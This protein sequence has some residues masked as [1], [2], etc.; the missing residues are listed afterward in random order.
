MRSKNALKSLLALFCYEAVIFATSIVYPR[1]I[2]LTYG[3]EVNGLS[4]TITRAL[5]LVSLIQAGAIGASIYQMYQP[6]AENDVVTQSEIMYSS[7][8][9]YKKIVLIYLSLSLVIA[10]FFS[11]YLGNETLF[12]KDIFL[13]F[14]I[15]A[16]NGGL[17]LYITSICDI[18]FSAHQKKY[19]VTIAQIVYQVV[20]YGC[21]TLVLYYKLSYIY[22]FLSMLLGGLIG[23]LINLLLYK[24]F[25]KGII[26][27]NPENKNY[28]IP[29]RR[30]LMLSCIG[31]EAVTTAPT[32]IVSTILGLIYS[33][34]FSVYSLVYMSMRTLISTIQLSVSPIF[35]NLV[36]T[37]DDSKLLYIYDLIELITVLFGTLLSAVAGV[38]IIPFIEIY[39]KDINDAEYLYPV[40]AIFVVAFIVFLT[41]SSA[42]GYVS[43]IYGLFK[44]T[45]TITLISSGVGI[46]ISAI[47]TVLWG[48]SYVMVGVIIYQVLSLL[49]TLKVLQKNVRWFRLSGIIKRSVFLI[50]ATLL[51]YNLYVM[52]RVEISTWSQWFR[53]A[54]FASIATGGIISIYVVLFERKPVRDIISYLLKSIKRGA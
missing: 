51:L 40:L 15:V 7:K 17:Q 4:T 9:Y 14:M 26:C 37:S 21:L 25:S 54:I 11:V 49:L 47:C 12:A 13:A 50:V 41:I 39:T 31:G 22:I 44:Q 52:C 23:V 34:V 38:L 2:I 3:S 33:S 28:V 16:V 6:V 45:C 36:K 18:F 53:A 20:N 29:G 30:Y 8:K 19:Y 24:S 5:S 1:W 32:I 48:I 46:V 10:A 43:T 35:G 42:F 27:P